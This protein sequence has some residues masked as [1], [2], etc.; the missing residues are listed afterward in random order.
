MNDSSESPFS[1]PDEGEDGMEKKEAIEKKE[2]DG[3]KDGISP[4]ATFLLSVTTALIAAVIAPYVTQY[5][6]NEESARQLEK[7]KREKIIATQFE[8]V[9]KFNSTFWRYRQ[10]AGFLTFDFLNSQSEAPEESLQQ[11]DASGP[12]RHGPVCSILGPI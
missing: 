7:T 6:K 12:Q 4:R 10:A 11:E 9:E 1:Q 3:Q 2:N 8:T 5:L